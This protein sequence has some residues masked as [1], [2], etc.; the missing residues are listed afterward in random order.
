MSHVIHQVGQAFEKYTLAGAATEAVLHPGGVRGQVTGTVGSIIGTP[1]APGQAPPVP[2]PQNE[3]GNEA[4]AQLKAE[5]AAIAGRTNTI[6]TSGLGIQGGKSRKKK[7]GA[8]SG[9]SQ[10]GL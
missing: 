7:L 1:K 9:N 2:T 8:G 10:L 3:Q 5:R 6:L 4:Q